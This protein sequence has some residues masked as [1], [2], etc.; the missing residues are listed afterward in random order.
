MLD[1]LGITVTKRFKQKTVNVCHGG[2]L[3]ECLTLIYDGVIKNVHNPC[4]T[5][6]YVQDNG[7]GYRRFLD[8]PEI[9]ALTE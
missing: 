2:V 9:F 8:S 4:I 7:G 3:L 1:M 5:V 6:E